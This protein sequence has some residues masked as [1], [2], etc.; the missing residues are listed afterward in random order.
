MR[1][2]GEEGFK[3]DYRLVPLTIFS[4]LEVASVGL[5]EK[6]LQRMN[7]K[8][9]KFKV[10][11]SFLSAVKIKG[12]KNAFAKILLNEALNEVYGIHIVAPSASEVISSYMPLYLGKISFRE[13]S[14]TPYPH[15]TVS[16]SLRDLAEYIVGEPVHLFKK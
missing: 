8:Y 7:V 14:H 4:G 5:T 13:A 15:L 16:E 10:P 12:Y 6:E 3:I 11:L 9:V 1:I 2:A